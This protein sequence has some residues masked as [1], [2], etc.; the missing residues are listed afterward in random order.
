[1]LVNIIPVTDAVYLDLL[2]SSDG[3]S[4]YD[5]G[6][7]DYR[8]VFNSSSV[9]V[10]D[11]G[12]AGDAGFDDSAIRLTGNTSGA[13]NQIGSAS[14]EYGLSG[15]I[16]LYDPASTKGTQM[17]WDLTYDS[18]TPESMIQICKGGATRDSAADVDGIRLAF[19]SGNL[20]TGQ[21]NVYGVSNA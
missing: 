1:V 2:T 21:I 15:Q 11:G 18:S 8:W 19:S 3:G 14:G 20:E 12:V 10:S 17:T 9:N 16:W 7:S 13:A 6:S 4:S 5:T